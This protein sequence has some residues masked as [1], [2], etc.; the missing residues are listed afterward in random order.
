MILPFNK[1]VIAA[2]DSR[3]LSCGP[4]RLKLPQDMTYDPHGGKPVFDAG[5]LILTLRQSL[6]APANYALLDLII[7][8]FHDSLQG[9]GKRLASARALQL[10]HSLP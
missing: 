7:N 8:I 1:P 2:F 9:C 3:I 6:T 10:T 5:F 4:G